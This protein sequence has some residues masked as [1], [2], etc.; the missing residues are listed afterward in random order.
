MSQRSTGPRPKA[1]SP[2]WILGGFGLGAAFVSSFGQTFFIG[3]FGIK[4]Q[5]AHDLTPSTLGALYG[6][7]TLVSGALMFWC[8]ELA[9]RVRLGRAVALAGAL[10][11]AG[12][13]L[14]SVAPGVFGLAL[15]FLLLRFGGQ[16]LM[17]HL[18]LVTA[19]RAT[20]TMRG[21]SVAIAGLGFIIGQAVWPAIVS[22]A[23][24]VA[25]WQAIWLAAAALVAFVA[26]PAL[27]IAARHCETG[28]KEAQAGPARH[29]ADLRRPGLLSEPRFLS[30]LGL[31]LVPP[32][33]VTAVFFH[34][35]SLAEA[36]SWSSG[37][38]ASGFV[39]FALAQLAALAAAGRWIDRMGASSL[40]RV[41]LLPLALGT[42]GIAFAGSD[43]Y[44][45]S[46]FAAL[47]LTSG[48]NG[49]IGGALWAEIF[50]TRQVGMVR[51]VY[52][53]FAVAAT[54]VSPYL[55]GE[56]LARSASLVWLG[57]ACAAYCMLAPL[58]LVRYI[59]RCAARDGERFAQAQ[60]VAREGPI[61]RRQGDD[62]RFRGTVL[63]GNTLR[64]TG[65]S[66]PNRAFARRRGP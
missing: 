48:A 30:A 66:T 50:G 35:S 56:A 58:V 16:G 7:A 61:C 12:C 21:R 65:P 25:N 51:G 54:G 28:V 38:V 33:V 32:F 8:G 49:V 23:A 57:G 6:A 64:R 43:G 2:G 10:L 9:D 20:A 19:A 13:T 55:L 47:G 11:A 37:T 60:G 15:A 1:D 17:S 62:H 27:R 26:I 14:V 4:L 22:V 52:A 45:W 24:K 59:R 5:A 31:V 34:L 3:L 42:L 41:H 46:I 39:V 36:A 53:A 40:L 63:P 44:A 18:A 29:D